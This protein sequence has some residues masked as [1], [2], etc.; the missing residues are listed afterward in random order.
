MRLKLSNQMFHIFIIEAA[1]G[2]NNI[3]YVYDTILNHF[4]S[5]QQFVLHDVRQRH[6]IDRRLI[7]AVMKYLHQLQRFVY[8][9]YVASYTNQIK[10]TLA[11]GQNIILVNTSN[12]NKRG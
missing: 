8:I 5:F 4:K 1:I 2:V 12:I 11:A 9:L 6:D 3:N 7:T 10:K